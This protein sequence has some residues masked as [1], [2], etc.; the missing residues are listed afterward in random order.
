MQE[1]IVTTILIQFS[2]ASIFVIASE[3]LILPKVGAEGL[4]G[5]LQ[6]VISDQKKNCILNQRYKAGNR[7][8]C[9]HFFSDFRNNK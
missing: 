9:S 2:S 3:R 5:Q 8:Y 1:E 6:K 4:T 7:N